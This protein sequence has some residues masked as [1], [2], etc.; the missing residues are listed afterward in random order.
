MSIS[1]SKVSFN[2]GNII[3]SFWSNQETRDSLQTKRPDPVFQCHRLIAQNG[4][5][6]SKAGVRGHW[7]RLLESRFGLDLYQSGY[8]CVSDLRA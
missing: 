8:R 7:V 1:F 6:P 2:I 3:N 4:L 5:N